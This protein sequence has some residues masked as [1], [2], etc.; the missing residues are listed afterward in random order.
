MSVTGINDQGH[1]SFK[2]MSYFKSQHFELWKHVK[3]SIFYI[4]FSADVDAK[5]G[6]TVTIKCN[7]N[8]HPIP[9]IKWIREDKQ[10]IKTK[11]SNSGRIVKFDQTIGPDL[12]IPNIDTTDMGSYLCIADNGVPPIVSKRIYVYVQCKLVLTM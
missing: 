1:N 4:F 3:G 5:L 7:A 9:T 12:V 11:D 2:N 8:G 6:S 10:L